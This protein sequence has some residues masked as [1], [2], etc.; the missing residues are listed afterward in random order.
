MEQK[1]PTLKIKVKLLANKRRK[2]KG[3]ENNCCRFFEQYGMVQI[4][5]LTLKQIAQDLGI[6]RVLLAT[7]HFGY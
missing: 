3:L 1:P 6:A 7:F 2:D 4:Q 5:P